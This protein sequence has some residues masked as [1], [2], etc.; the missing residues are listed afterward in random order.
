MR[1]LSLG[2]AI[3]VICL[4]ASSSFAASLE[5]E[6]FVA[7]VRLNGIFLSLASGLASD[8]S[9][10]TGLRAF[11]DREAPDM[12]AVTANVEA[13]TAPEVASRA[14]PMTVAT[15]DVVTG[16]S[17]AVDSSPAETNFSAPVG[18]GALMP[19]AAITLDRLSASKG[20]AFDTLYKAT[21]VNALRQLA[22]LYNAYG[23]TGD[24][25]ALKQL[26]K[27]ELGATNNRIAEIGRF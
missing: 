12:E 1:T 3:A 21:Q 17:V 2:T 11:A 22:A 9:E 5:T 13:R 25:P 26:A 10:N 18:T 20:Q 7:N 8:R 24:D 14:V 15:N 19:A 27:T 4:T 16:R 6:V 23:M